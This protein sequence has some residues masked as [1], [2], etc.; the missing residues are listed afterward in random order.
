M[1]NLNQIKSNVM[2]KAWEIARNASK[3]FGNKVSEYIGEAM[4]LAWALVKKAEKKV[5]QNVSVV[6]E[7][8]QPKKEVSQMAIEKVDMEALSSILTILNS[9]FSGNEDSTIV[10]KTDF[11]GE[12]YMTVHYDIVEGHLFEEVI[13]VV[14]KEGEISRIQYDHNRKGLGEIS[15]EVFKKGLLNSLRN[16]A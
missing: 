12:V 16:K 3:K 15:G 7:N 10:E 6:K 11:E 8:A 14:D 5:E 1:T 2:A 9:A 13:V 4:K